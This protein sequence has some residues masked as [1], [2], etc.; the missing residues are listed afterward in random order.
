MSVDLEERPA[1]VDLD[2]VDDEV[3]PAATRPRGPRGWW[4]DVLHAPA[5]S[6][7]G[8]LVVLGCCTFVLL[9]LHPDLIF[10]KTTPAG[11][12][13][14]AHVWGPAYIRDDLLP[15]G[16]LT[17]WSPDWYAG[18][19]AFQFYMLPPALLVVLLDVV[20]PYGIALKVVTVLGLVTMPL[21][22]YVMGRLMRL[23]F[24]GPPLLAVATVP[25]IF[26]R[27]WTIYGGNAAS[28]LAGEYSFSISLSLALVFFGVLSRG[29]ETGR[30]R[31]LASA[32]L[33]LVI[34]C[35][36]IPA[37]FAIVGA[38]V[39][40]LLRFDWR[41]VVFAAPVLAV[42]CLLTAFWSIP[43][44]LRRGYLTDMGW[45]KL[46]GYSDAL[47]P[48]GQRW[49]AVLALVGLVL[50]LAFWIRAGAAFGMLAVLAGLGFWLDAAS[51]VHIWN[52]R[53]L[54]FYY[55]CLYLL[56]AIGVS[57]VVR[58]IAV[59][60]DAR[61]EWVRRL[62]EHIG[63]VVA[64][65][66]AIVVVALPLQVLPGGRTGADGKY[67]WLFLETTD[68]SFVD[69]WAAWNYSGYERKP[70]YP[71]YRAVMATMQEVGRTEGCG[72]AHWEYDESLNRYGTPMA[73]MLLPFWT[74]GCIG[75]MEGLYFESSGTTPF[76]FLNAAE[77][78]VKPS[79]PV[80]DLPDRPMKYSGFD[81]DKGVEH[82]QLFGVRYYLAFSEQAVA[83]AARHPDL[84]E[85]AVSP[86][87]HVY[88]IADSDLVEPLQ[89][90]PAVL[91]GMSD[92]NP[93]WQRDAVAWYNDRE[94]LDV[95][96]APRGPDG[97]ERVQR[98][99]APERERLPRT[100]VTNIDE[101]E[102]KISFDVDRTGQPILVKTSY[103][104][105]WS[106]S[107]AEGPYRVTPN[108]MVV[109]PTQEHVELTYG[110][111]SVEYLG[112]GLS[113][114]GLVGVGLL[115]RRGAVAL[116]EPAPRRRRDDEDGEDDSWEPAAWPPAD[117]EAEPEPEPA[118][119]PVGFWDSLLA[120]R[121]AELAEAEER[122]ED[123][124]GDGG[125]GRPPL[126]D[127]DWDLRDDEPGPLGP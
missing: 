26:D 87:W 79:N 117:G 19:P 73:M 96:L 85:V 17:G 56:A 99:E 52:A 54:P 38:V 81:L 91:E 9:Q 53:L 20:L 110:N 69:G 107:G 18:F 82:L 60:V 90:E 14:G 57:E 92:A 77:T 71:E 80:R 55:L 51:P 114:A 70:D 34:L 75:S 24:P 21:A 122:P 10:A 28:T 118:P 106:V 67:E 48:D 63:A 64:G 27:A 113:L 83:A 86:P 126:L 120:E 35:H 44:V 94:A 68:R 16:R 103:F 45:E 104:P 13:M 40:V 97:W 72:R 11:G 112:W 66:A 102:L 109:I 124:P 39:L 100:R 36:A 76:H 115:V 23:P 37:F 111:T 89:Y 31:G 4:F 42:G 5:E 108:L 1:A 98:G 8:A 3:G 105:N 127:P 33:A 6:W 119:R 49:V 58:S 84:R 41:R 47:L 15:H 121:K 93:A 22:A 25:F 7:L 125:T 59:I 43:F 46:T 50:S 62:A 95:V 61:I 88:E 2:D 29:L 65:L 123:A 32:L 116:P 12:D 30:H 101:D 74:D 78:S